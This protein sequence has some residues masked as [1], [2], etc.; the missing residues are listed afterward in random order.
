MCYSTDMKTLRTAYLTR[1]R[2]LQRDGFTCQYCGQRAPNVVLQVDHR[3]PSSQGG[4]DDDANLVTACFACNVGKSDWLI[5]TG[6]K[7][8][9]DHGIQRERMA[10]LVIAYIAS[11]GPS[12]ATELANGLG[13]NRSSASTLLA[14]D[15]RF[16]FVGKRGRDALYALVDDGP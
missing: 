4:T 15:E 9:P 14:N 6:A 5:V 2:I 12:S 8:R 11:H 3:I 7:P 16:R 1:W 10:P 13:F